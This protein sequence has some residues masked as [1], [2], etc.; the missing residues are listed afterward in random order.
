MEP[1]A[2]FASDP[3]ICGGQW[4]I[5]G[6]RVPVRTILASLAEGAGIEDIRRDFP[7]VSEEAIRDVIRFA[8]ASAEEDVPAPAVP[9]V[10]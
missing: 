8:A 2:F 3:A 10:A 9:T 5:R 1:T 4:V 7:T 6:T